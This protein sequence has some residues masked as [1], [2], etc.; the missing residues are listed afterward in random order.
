[1]FGVF[2]SDHVI[3]EPERYLDAVRPA[4][5]AAVRGGIAVLGIQ[6][7]WAETGYGY[8]E[9]EDGVQAGAL[10]T[11]PV[12]SF[13]EKP[14]LAAAEKYLAAGRFFWNAGMFFW[15]ADVLLENLRNHLP[16]TATL[17]AG[18]PAFADADFPSRLREVFPLCENISIDYAV[19]EKATGVVGVACGGIR[20]ERRRQLGCRLRAAAARRRPERRGRS[21]G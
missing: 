6:P 13:R 17:L 7:R 11:S 19:I 3:A 8:I 10:E 12:L 16:K 9:F 2:P 18:L 1:M 21:A 20:L 5:E 15:R 4:F 14:E